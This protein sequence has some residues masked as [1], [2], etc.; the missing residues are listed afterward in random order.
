MNKFYS[1]IVLILLLLLTILTAQATYGSQNDQWLP[2]AC[3]SFAVYSKHPIYGMNFDFPDVELLFV[4]SKTRNGKVFR[5]NAKFRGGYI[6]IAG[7]N[8]SGLMGN[9]QMLFPK[10]ELKARA[11]DNELY[12]WE[13]FNTALN[14]FKTVQE[15]LQHIKHKKIIQGGMTLHSLYADAGGEAFILE[16]VKNKNKII[17]ITK[18]FLVMTNFPVSKFQGKSYQDVKGSGANRYKIAYEHIR[19]H[20]K[21]F[22]IAEGMTTLKKT[23]MNQKNF[24]TLCSLVFDPLKLNI[25]II[26]RRDFQRIWKISLKNSTIQPHSGFKEFREMRLDESGI[27]ASELLKP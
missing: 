1:K 12:L 24:S 17:Q 10:E 18:Q 19:D 6:Q 11:A 21:T 4:I 22:D 8:S 14:R 26:L 2:F 7:M 3:T 9:F 13:I 20:L 23:S 16:P 15:V 25:Y 5:L 27:K